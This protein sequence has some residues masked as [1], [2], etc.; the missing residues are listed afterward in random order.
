MAPTRTIVLAAAAIALAVTL[1][2]SQEGPTIKSES[3]V[4]VQDPA[5]VVKMMCV[6]DD[7]LREK[8]RQIL[9]DG[10]DDALKTQI[11]T[12]Y[13]VWMRDN[14]GQPQRAAVG[15]RKAIVAYLEG[16][17]SAL[18]WSPPLCAPGLP[19]SSPR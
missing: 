8:V 1:V 5:G 9:L 3:Y 6:S 14:A 16:R 4:V 19:S 11:E 2:S 15:V 10:L 17:T 7:D 13:A 18:N 12:V